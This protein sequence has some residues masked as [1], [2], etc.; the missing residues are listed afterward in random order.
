[1]RTLVAATGLVLLAT[2]AVF[3]MTAAPAA[4]VV[5]TA[6][7]PRR[8]QDA[9]LACPEAPG[10]SSADATCADG[11]PPR[12]LKMDCAAADEDGNTIDTPEL[13]PTEEGVA[14]TTGTC[15]D[16]SD[17]VDDTGAI[18]CA[19]GSKPLCSDGMPA[20]CTEFSG[21]D[22]SGL[23]DDEMDQFKDGAKVAALQAS[24]HIVGFQASALSDCTCSDGC[25]TAT[26][27]T[28]EHPF[29][30][31]YPSCTAAGPKGQLADGTWDPL[32]AEGCV[33][34]NLQQPNADGKMACLA[35]AEAVQQCAA[36][37]CRNGGICVSGGGSAPYAC[38]CPPAFYGKNCQYNVDECSLPKA[39]ST[40]GA[41]DAPSDY[42]NRNIYPCGTNDRSV[43]TD[44]VGQMDSMWCN[45]I[46][47]CNRYFANDKQCLDC[48][49]NQDLYTAI[50]G[51]G[52]RCQCADHPSNQMEVE[53]ANGLVT[54][55][56]RVGNGYRDQGETGGL[57][58]TATQPKLTA[59]ML[60]LGGEAP[61]AKASGCY[62]FDDCSSSPCQ[63]GGTC[64]DLGFFAYA[65]ACTRGWTG[66]D[67]DEDIPECTDGTHTCVD[68]YKE[69]TVCKDAS[70]SSRDCQVRLGITDR[71]EH[72]W[73]AGGQTITGLSIPYGACIEKDGGY[74]CRCQTGWEGD[75]FTTATGANG[76]PG[77]NIAGSGC[78]DIPNCDRTPGICKHG[79]TCSEPPELIATNDV[80]C[81]CPLG[82]NGLDA[83][84]PTP[85]AYYCEIDDNECEIGASR[86]ICDTQATCTNT[87]G[88]YTCACNEGWTGTGITCIDADDCEFSPCA[89]GGTCSD[90]GTLMFDCVCVPGWRGPKCEDDWN[91]CTMG[92]H[93]CHNDAS[94]IN[95]DG[96]YTCACDPGYSGDGFAVCDDVDDCFLYKQDDPNF[97]TTVSVCVHGTCEDRGANYFVCTCDVGYTD[98]NCDRD[99]NE[100]NLINGD[101]DCDVN[102]GCV[103]TDGSYMCVCNTGFTGAGNLNNC[104]AIED[105][106]S[107]PCVTEN[108]AACEEED[109]GGV[110]GLYTCKCKTGYTDTKCSADINECDANNVN[111]CDE[112]AVCEN[113]DGSYTCKCQWGYSGNGIKTDTG[114]T[115]CVDLDDCASGPCDHVPDD[116]GCENL[117]HNMFR[118]SCDEGWTDTLCDFD[119]NECFLKTHNCHEVAKCVN[120]PGAYRCRCVSGYEGDGYSMDHVHTDYTA[121]DMFLERGDGGADEDRK[122]LLM[123]RDNKETREHVGA[124]ELVGTKAFGC[125][126]LDDC[127]SAP[128]DPE[129]NGARGTC[130]DKGP[131]EF[132]C[133][134]IIGWQGDLCTVDIDECAEE[135]RLT[136]DCDTRDQAFVGAAPQG[137]RSICTN[138]QGSHSC[139]CSPGY[140]DTQAQSEDD[141]ADQL[142]GATCNLCTQCAIGYKEERKCQPLDRTCV[143]V[144]E[145]VEQNGSLNNCNIKA[146]CTD[147]EGS[148]TC[149]C[150]GG[151]YGDGIQCVAC[152]E[153]VTGE[154]QTKECTSTQNRECELHVPN[155][156][157]SISNFAGADD[158]AGGCLAFQSMAASDQQAWAYPERR[159]YG[160]GA[161]DAPFCGYN[162]GDAKDCPDSTPKECLL[163]EGSAVFFFHHLKGY[164]YTISSKEGDDWKCL[165]FGANGDAYP[166]RDA[167]LTAPICDMGEGTL[168]RAV[169]KVEPIKRS[170][171]KFMLMATKAPWIIAADEGAP[172]YEC[173]AFLMGSSGVDTNPSLKNWGSSTLFCGMTAYGEDGAVTRSGS[174]EANELDANG[175][176]VWVLDQL[177]GPPTIV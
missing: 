171:K 88:S 132:F 136:N 7:A 49:Q 162:S 112:A 83:M 100:C 175:Q 54:R 149:E 99:T 53:G 101:N 167:Q 102:A 13:C 43:C 115:G 94:C 141:T 123:T 66:K 79:G 174:A 166:T 61:D 103:N 122:N 45:S 147:T 68:T 116:G 37:P 36:F 120:T 110:P 72:T 172:K 111:N 130:D 9:T 173:L 82:W 60:K 125:L 39:Y 86:N 155:G 159:V 25:T 151:Y 161:V 70:E 168:P 28:Y 90:I 22:S 121:R 154:H 114:G 118:C 126:D 44:M 73:E 11:M 85:R 24:V 27:V 31:D 42:V 117:L 165:S 89:N 76:F 129:R 177:A 3:A 74:G 169:W 30:Y 160:S 170:E 69:E 71:A 109:L 64:T 12:A 108:T 97:I 17:G 59:I 8:L 57:P 81:D 56:G 137:D 127:A 144:D 2:A 105:C 6:A 148:F 52:Y 134:C 145:C 65:C 92:V 18:G 55:S 150:N 5:V 48:A 163:S 138:S 95:N 128:C 164:E 104:A 67:C 16:G 139:E 41:Y 106:A 124:D 156:L 77:D 23:S 143:N 20:R 15:A 34:A 50:R 62:D 1:L 84:H 38:V 135:N 119:I 19:D 21:L 91:E 87:D 75:G 96:S 131:N 176:A 35:G 78:V 32:P 26:T 80:H 98:S 63:H 51:E 14:A 47:D 107:D 10:V 29:K 93:A 58:A 133:N 142:P 46:E 152:T 146:S 157:Y 158:S 4:E 140:Y 153:C 113:T 40:G 33:G